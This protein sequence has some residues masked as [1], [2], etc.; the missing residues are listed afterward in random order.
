MLFKVSAETEN[1]QRA[2]CSNGWKIVGDDES[3]PH[4]VWFSK[5]MV[6]QEGAEA[7]YEG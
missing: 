2:A 5:I 7:R 6:T 4:D 1:T 3:F